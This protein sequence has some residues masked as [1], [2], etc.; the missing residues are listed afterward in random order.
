MPKQIKSITLYDGYVTADGSSAL[1]KIGMEHPYR[2]VVY[3]T[4]A[5]I[6]GIG[7]ITFYV[8]GSPDGST[9]CRIFYSNTSTNYWGR[10]ISSPVAS[11]IALT[12]PSPSF[13]GNWIGLE[14]DLAATIEP[15]INITAKAVIEKYSRPEMR[16]VA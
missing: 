15:A 10:T 9:K 3:V 11:T 6:T 5:E 1:A 4:I 8:L 13:I 2:I 12:M 16:G 14:W 7:S